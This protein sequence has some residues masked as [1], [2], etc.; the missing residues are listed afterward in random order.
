MSLLFLTI[1]VFTALGYS[2]VSIKDGKIR[3]K[4]YGEVDDSLE[5]PATWEGAPISIGQT[6]AA[7]AAARGGTPAPPAAPGRTVWPSPAP[8]AWAPGAPLPSG[9]PPQPVPVASGVPAGVKV[10]AALNIVLGTVGVLLNGARALFMHINRGQ[11]VQFGQAGFVVEDNP[12]LVAWMAADAVLA[13]ALAVSAIGL[14]RLR[15]WG[16]RLA[17]AAAALQLASSGI[18]LGIAVHAATTLAGVGDEER[19]RVVSM[20]VGQFIGAILGAIYPTVVL[21]VLGRRAAASAFQPAGD[22]R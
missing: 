5:T 11:F 9:Y 17:L 16:R 3:V 10:I 15:P 8:G 14:F 7:P 22:A 20:L 1:L 18:V 13:V 2:D 21:V 4:R 12:R 6:L 19:R